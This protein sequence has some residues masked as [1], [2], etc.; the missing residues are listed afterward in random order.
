MA[1]TY[2][3]PLVNYVRS[4]VP[5]L[6]DSQVRYLME[7]FRKLE[8]TLATYKAALDQLAPRVP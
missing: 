4:S 6:P 8:Q 3:T 1:V 7:E 5:P 2:T